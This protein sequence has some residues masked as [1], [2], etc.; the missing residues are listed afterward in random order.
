MVCFSLIL[1]SIL[2]GRYYP[3]NSLDG[4]Y[5]NFH[6]FHSMNMKR[7]T[8]MYEFTSTEEKAMNSE[9]L[10][11]GISCY[12]KRTLGGKGLF[13]LTS[14]GL[15][16]REDRSKQ[17][18]TERPERSA[19]Y[20]LAPHGLLSLLFYATQGQWQHHT[21]LTRLSILISQIKEMP[22][23]LCLQ[24]NLRETFFFS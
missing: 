24:A 2:T 23:L 9:T 14:F 13:L 22:P 7:N 5:Y 4:F 15:L 19:A 11:Q 8:F 17:E 21:Q 6:G 1:T 10:S 16:S 18:L 3:V 12:D 20:E